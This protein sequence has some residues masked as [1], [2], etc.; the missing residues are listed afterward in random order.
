MPDNTDSNNAREIAVRN[1]ELRY[2]KFLALWHLMRAQYVS[3]YAVRMRT[4]DQIT[5]PRVEIQD[6]LTRVGEGGEID[7]AQR[8]ERHQA[9]GQEKQAAQVRC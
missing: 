2:G 9:H 7:K 4:P 1:H 6:C 8:R 5:S 3:F